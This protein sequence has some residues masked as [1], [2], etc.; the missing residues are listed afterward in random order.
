MGAIVVRR[1]RAGRWTSGTVRTGEGSARDEGS[2]PGPPLG[3]AIGAAS[4]ALPTSGNDGPARRR[5]RAG[6]ILTVFRPT[7]DSFMALVDWMSVQTRLHKLGFD[8]G[9]IDGI[10]GRRTVRAV[11][12]FQESKSLV[13]DGIVGPDTVH[14][15]FG[16]GKADDPP[17]FDRIPWYHEA[18]RLVGTKEL[19]GPASNANILEMADRQARHRLRGRRHPAVR[20]VRGALRGRV[21]ARRG[22]ADGRAARPRLGGV[23]GAGEP[24]ARCGHGVLAPVAGRR[25]PD[26]GMGHVGF[27]FAE[28]ERTYHVLGGNQSN[29]VRV[30]RLRK[31]RLLTA[32]WPISALAPEDTVVVVDGAAGAMSTDE[33]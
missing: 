17:A 14:A 6:M 18:L 11:K 10:R 32:R 3:T 33:C 13:A 23:R 7:E 8:P 28:D 15:L 24:A 30:A 19:E 12:R 2:D 20:T 16:E 26:S 31:D 4:A 29:M 5:P 1:R 27:Y 25:S 21:A 22:P 9:L